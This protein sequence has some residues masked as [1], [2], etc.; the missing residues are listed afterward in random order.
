[1][2]PAL[3][4]PS[5]AVVAPARADDE[6]TLAALMDLFEPE[7]PDGRTSTLSTASAARAALRTSANALRTWRHERSLWSVKVT[8]RLGGTR[9]AW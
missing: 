5:S 7:D 4:A 1:V 2:P 9:R 6:L 8:V 3:A